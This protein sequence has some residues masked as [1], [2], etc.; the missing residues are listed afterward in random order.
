MLVL[1]GINL[2]ISFGIG[3]FIERKISKRLAS[4][5][6]KF[7]SFFIAI[8]IALGLMDLLKHLITMP[9]LGLRSNGTEAWANFFV[10]SIVWPTLLFV[11]ILIIE[12]YKKRKTKS[13]SKIKVSATDDACWGMALEEFENNPNKN[14]WAKCF[15]ES[16]GNESIAKA[17]YIEIRAKQLFDGKDFKSEPLI[18]SSSGGENASIIDIIKAK[19][20]AKENYKNI[21]YFIIKDIGKFACYQDGYFYVF[22]DKSEL[23]KAIETYSFYDMSNEIYDSTGRKVK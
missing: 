23:L 11:I 15:A 5:A 16:K 3:F 14:I 20:Y 8:F 9:A 4:G 2:I 10:K 12:F 22:N 13:K 1:V 19:M 17:K 18:A 7:I 6:S 21:E